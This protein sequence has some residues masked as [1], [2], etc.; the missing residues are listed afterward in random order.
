VSQ[1]DMKSVIPRT[2]IVEKKK[3]T[4][5][6]KLYSLKC[7]ANSGNSVRANSLL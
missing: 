1:R 7:N 5:I 2:V 6:I 3:C 4:V